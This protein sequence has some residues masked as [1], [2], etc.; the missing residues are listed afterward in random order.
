MTY[1]QLLDW[2][3]RHS[4]VDDTYFSYPGNEDCVIGATNQVFYD[5]N[6][7]PLS[8]S[9]TCYW[10][11]YGCDVHN[12]VEYHTAK[13]LFEAPIYE[14]LSIRD[15]WDEITWD[16]IDGWMREEDFDRLFEREPSTSS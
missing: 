2:F 10:A 13:E 1:E 7:R 9:E 15:R 3:D 6:L 14:G 12:G 16:R 4:H 5:S 11:G 8:H